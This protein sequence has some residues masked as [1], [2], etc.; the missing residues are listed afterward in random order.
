MR[1]A[2]VSIVRGDLVPADIGHLDFE[3]RFV[4]TRDDCD[5]CARAVTV[6]LIINIM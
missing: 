1:I 6:I 5:L 4:Q 3:S 2:E